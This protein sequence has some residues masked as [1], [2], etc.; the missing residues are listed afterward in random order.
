MNIIKKW[1]L[2]VEDLEGINQYKA[3]TRKHADGSGRALRAKACRTYKGVQK[4]TCHL[5]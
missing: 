4:S 5:F 3:L 1:F 2:M